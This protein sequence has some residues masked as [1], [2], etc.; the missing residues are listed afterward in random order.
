MILYS[1]LKRY[2]NDESWGPSTPRLLALS[3]FYYFMQDEAQSSQ[4]RSCNK[5]GEIQRPDV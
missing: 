1:F 5:Q 2:K 3:T 4:E